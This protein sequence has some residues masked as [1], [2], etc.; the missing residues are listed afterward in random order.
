MQLGGTLSLGLLT[1]SLAQ[2][3]PFWVCCLFFDTCNMR[4]L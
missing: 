1:W 2:V 4:H 3:T